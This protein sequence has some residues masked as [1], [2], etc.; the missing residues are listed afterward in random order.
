[1]KKL[2][3]LGGLPR[4]GNTLL[5]SWFMQHPN[6]AVTA[7]SNLVNIL[8]Q[9][10]NIKRGEFHK[11]FPDDQS[12]NNVLDNVVDQYYSHWKE[13]VIIDRAPWGT[14]GNISLIKKYIKPKEIK[15]IFLKRPLKEILGSFYKMG[16]VYQNMEHVMAPNQMVQFDYRSVGT[17][18]Q[19]PTIKKLII[20]YDDLA[21]NPQNV[22][23]KISEYCG[24]ESIKLDLNNIQQL[25]LNGVKYNDEHVGA[26]LHTIRTDK[27]E[28][29]NH[30]YDSILPEK[31]YN[32]Y[33]YL[34]KTWEK[35]PNF[36]FVDKLDI[37]EAKKYVG[38]FLKD[39]WD[40]YT[41]RQD[42]FEVHNQT[43]TIPIIYDENFDEAISKEHHHYLFFKN[44]LEPIEKSLLQKHST[45]SIVRA[46]LV[47][48]PVKCSIPPHQDY[49]KSLENTYRYHIPI[50]TNK[51]VVFTVGGES[52]NLEEGY[53]WEIKNSE[54]VH[55]V[56][57]NGQI[58]RIHL[59]I[60]WKK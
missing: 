12:I 23:D 7:H 18:L 9:L 57:N 37:S 8:F 52:K 59:I 34:D 47:K 46:I 44:I 21:T 29:D 24:V 49:G 42:T 6:I 55:S 14:L 48:L 5:A 17:V 19:D 13:D 38:S 41:F 4:A 39:E 32:K 60:D 40:K 16:G 11:N 53:I 2:I 20:E 33:K 51:D 50:V 15:F 43:K 27:I 28:K 22:V 58:D 1:M 45:G 25:E 54:K 35:T 10:E 26:P 56:T 36:N 31:I 3:F 30:D